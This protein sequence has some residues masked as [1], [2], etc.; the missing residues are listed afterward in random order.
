MSESTESSPKAGKEKG[1][2]LDVQMSQVQNV[3]IVPVNW[4][5]PWPIL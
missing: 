3:A 4:C 5:I 1:R 2:G